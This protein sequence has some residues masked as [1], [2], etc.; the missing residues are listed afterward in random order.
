MVA[1]LFFA[2]QALSGDPLPA[3]LV[4]RGGFRVA[5]AISF[6][7]R[8]GLWAAT[9]KVKLRSPLGRPRNLVL[10]KP[11]TVSIQRRYPARTPPDAAILAASDGA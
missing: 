10:R 5:T 1:G 11:A 7:A 6:G 3:K 2:H 4:F 8:T 9:A